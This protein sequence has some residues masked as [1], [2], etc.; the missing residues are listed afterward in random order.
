MK[1]QH[2]SSARET[3]T[4]CPLPALSPYGCAPRPHQHAYSHAPPCLVC[5]QSLHLALLSAW[6]THCLPQHLE[7][8]FLFLTCHPNLLSGPF[9]KPPTSPSL[10]EYLY[11]PRRRISSGGMVDWREDGGQADFRGE[12]VPAEKITR[13]DLSWK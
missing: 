3:P 8:A 2:L 7:G 9:G 5:L 4:V 13:K 1:P 11:S 12:N 10:I 6:T